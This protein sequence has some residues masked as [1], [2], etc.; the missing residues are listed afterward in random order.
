MPSPGQCPPPDTVLRKAA[1]CGQ[2]LV[3]DRETWSF[4]VDPPDS[5]LRGE[6]CSKCRLQLPKK[7]PYW[8]PEER[9]ISK[10]GKGYEMP[11]SILRPG[12]ERQLGPGPKILGEIKTSWRAWLLSFSGSRSGFPRA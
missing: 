12:I 3:K 5:Y 8:S 6:K 2:K 9:F 1:R 10:T 7:G 4:I 11:G